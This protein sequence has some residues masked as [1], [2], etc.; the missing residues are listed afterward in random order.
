[1]TKVTVK[2]FNFLDIWTKVL[3]NIR[4]S[5]SKPSYETWIAPLTAQIEDED[6]V[7]IKAPNDFAKDWIEVRYK[8]LIFE[9]IRKVTGSTFEIE[10]VGIERENNPIPTITRLN[11]RQALGYFLL[12]CNEAN[13]PKST[14]N[15]IYKNMR[16]QFD[17]KTPE[18]AEKEG[19]EWYR[20]LEKDK[21]Q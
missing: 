14:I 12:A 19:Y 17:I 18:E 13:I 21:I 6:I 16:W 4:E 9:S 10:V 5:I 3:E 2:N 11:I 8:E 7:I 20:S 1:M 15:E